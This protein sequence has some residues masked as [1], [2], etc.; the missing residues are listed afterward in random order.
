MPRS[1]DQLPPSPPSLAPA[2]GAQ[3]T[4][5]TE[6]A[7]RRQRRELALAIDKAYDHIPRLLRGAVRRA[8]GT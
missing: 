7:L 2:H 1:T 5:L 3:L 8:L 6:Q 4:A